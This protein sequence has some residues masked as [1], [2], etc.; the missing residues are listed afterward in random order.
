MPEVHPLRPYKR[1]CEQNNV[2]GIVT[3][4][5]LACA[6]LS[7]KIREH[8]TK[9]HLLIR[10]PCV[11]EIERVIGSEKFEKAVGKYTRLL[12]LSKIHS[13]TDHETQVITL[14][15]DDEGSPDKTN[16]MGDNNDTV[17]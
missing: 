10:D 3:V 11:E 9:N 16:S 5:D 6:A 4:A 2:T 12:D 7:M 15:D 8:E 14:S 1:Y 17:Q 13:D